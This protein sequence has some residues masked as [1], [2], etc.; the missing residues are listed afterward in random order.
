VVL[1][2]KQELFSSGLRATNLNWLI[3]PPV[4]ELTARAVIRYRH[5]GVEARVFLENPGEVRVI[6]ETPQ[7][8]V[9]PG[10][11]V[12]FYQGERLIGGGWIEER[13]R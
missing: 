10:Q 3:D 12:A 1:G 5:L 9:A 6:F 13:V 7:T 4:G 8:A 11:A 2:Y